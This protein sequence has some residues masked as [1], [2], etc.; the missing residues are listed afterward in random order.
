VF[1]LVDVHE[2]CYDA[3]HYKRMTFYI[4]ATGRGWVKLGSMR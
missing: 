2:L 4:G 1:S 3:P